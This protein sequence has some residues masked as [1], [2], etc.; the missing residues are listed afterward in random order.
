[1]PGA[2]SNTAVIVRVPDGQPPSLSKEDIQIP[3]PESNQVLVNLSHVAQNP[4]DGAY[5]H[6][7]VSGVTPRTFKHLIANTIQSKPLTPTHSAT[8]PFSVAIS[9][10][11]SLSWEVVLPAMQREMLLR[12]W[13]G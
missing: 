8:E 7:L 5:L 12:G 4:T 6:L 2:K 13:C 3:S 10:V 1:M 11:K 9:S